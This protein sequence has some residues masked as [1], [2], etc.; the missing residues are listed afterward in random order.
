MRVIREV[1]TAKSIR[2]DDFTLWVDL[3]DGR[4]LGVPLAWFPQL[5]RATPEQRSTYTL[6]RRGVHWECVDE[7]ISITGL[8][9]GRGDTPNSSVGSASSV[10]VDAYDSDFIL[11]ACD[12]AAKLR[13]GRFDS[14]DVENVAEELDT[15]ARALRRELVD[16]LACLLQHL[17]QWEYL[18]GV[19][20]PAWYI[21][22]VEE[23]SM[24]PL[25][26]EDAPSLAEEWDAMYAKAW[27]SA[28]L[29]VSDSTGII[30]SLVPEQCP[31]GKAQLLSNAFWPG[32]HARE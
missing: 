14:L 19:R 15:L 8:L 16:R 26:L 9:A 17:A 31:Y 4:T 13:S 29:G 20:Q 10:L 24:I 22:I 27:E 11:W 32:G 3:A 6:S 28:R 2:F 18:S 30:A 5:V 7:N 25:I 23:R 1:V 21:A 12:Q